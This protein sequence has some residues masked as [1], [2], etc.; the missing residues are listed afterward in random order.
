[1]KPDEALE[2]LGETYRERNLVY[3]DNYK[4]H[5]N[6]MLALFPAGVPAQITK[7]DANRFGVLLM[8]IS[9][10]ERYIC[11]WHNGGH[12]DS[13]NDLSVYSQMLAELDREIKDAR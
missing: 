3:G 13:L 4:T 10:L 6:V 1:M 8:M 5:G 11:N 7:D 12:E 9:K 2:K